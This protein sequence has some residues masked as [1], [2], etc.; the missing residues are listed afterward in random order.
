MLEDIDADSV[1]LCHSSPRAVY[2]QLALGR[3]TGRCADG[4]GAD[5]VAGQGV[6]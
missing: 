3:E 4:E 2:Q 1:Q 5:G 6:N